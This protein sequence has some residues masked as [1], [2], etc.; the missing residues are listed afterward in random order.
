MDGLEKV[1]GRR[2]RAITTALMSGICLKTPQVPPRP[3][4]GAVRLVWAD[5]AAVAGGGVSGSVRGP[6]LTR[7]AS[8]LTCAFVCNL[9]LREGSPSGRW[10]RS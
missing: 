3:E 10:R 7:L 4:S 6:K 2:G 9:E 1:S 5:A 8:R